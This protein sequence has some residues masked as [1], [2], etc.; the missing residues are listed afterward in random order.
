MRLCR[1]RAAAPTIAAPTI[2]VYNHRIVAR[3]QN[4]A[5]TP[6]KSMFSTLR[7]AAVAPLVA[8]FLLAAP[9]L[10][11][12]QVF[13]PA[14]CHAKVHAPKKKRACLS[15][16]KRK[17]A[18]AYYRSARVGNRCRMLAVARVAKAVA[19]ATSP[20][21]T[22]LGCN[23]S[24]RKPAKRALCVKCLRRP[25]QHYFYKAAQPGKR[26]RLHV[27]PPNIKK[28]V[29]KAIV[30]AKQLPPPNAIVGAAGCQ[31]RVRNARK[32]NVCLA[33][34]ARRPKHWFFKKRKPG[35]RCVPV[36]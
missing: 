4:S 33:C 2:A 13:K 23:Q 31:K 20:V 27:P 21:T 9:S 8:T 19:A 11:S 6:E 14:G 16:V 15:C 29:A 35:M 36:R 18:H 5:K 1:L 12:A 32:R 17:R 28:G 25:R 22:V 26:C 30:R 3:L 7:R 24:V 34:V 10:V